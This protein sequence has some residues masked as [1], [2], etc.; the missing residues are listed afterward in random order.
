MAGNFP[1]MPSRKIPYDVDG[2][3][4]GIRYPTGTSPQ[5]QWLEWDGTWLKD[6]N[7]IDETQITW[8]PY[9]FGGNAATELAHGYFVENVW[10]FPETRDLYG[11]W[12]TLKALN[13]YAEGNRFI[14]ASSQDT[15]NGYDGTWTELADFYAAALGGKYDFGSGWNPR[16]GQFR[17]GLVTCNQPGTRGFRITS[18]QESAFISP[19]DFRA[20]HLWGSI[21]SGETPDRLLFIDQDTGLAYTKPQDWG[22]TPRGLTVDHDIKI[23]NNSATYDASTFTLSFSAEYLDSDTWHTIKETGGSFSTT[24][25]ITSILA[26]ASYPASTNV[27]TLRNAVPVD[28]L[29][30]LYEARLEASPPTWT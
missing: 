21:S 2:S 22:D 19:S 3:F 4:V 13:V 27:I 9:G 12:F 18:G 6:L 7:D 26:G 15:T 10:I 17:G 5:E 28:A 14:V 16:I 25:N 8:E 20:V 23:K 11:W 24:L 30:G 29:I 1:D